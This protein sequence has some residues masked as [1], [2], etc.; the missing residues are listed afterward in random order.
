MPPT[1]RLPP[2]DGRFAHGFTLHDTN[3]LSGPSMAMIR[4]QNGLISVI[5]G[6]NSHGFPV[7]EYVHLGTAVRNPGLINTA[8]FEHWHRPPGTD[9][10]TITAWAPFVEAVNQVYLGF[11]AHEPPDGAATATAPSQNAAYA[12]WYA[13]QAVQWFHQTRTEDRDVSS[14]TNSDADADAETW[15][16]DE[17]VAD[18][19]EKL[20]TFIGT[21]KAHGLHH[22]DIHTRWL[23]QGTD[24]II[25]VL[26]EVFLPYTVSSTALA[27]D[28]Q[29]ISYHPRQ[30]WQAIEET[31]TAWQ[32]MV[33]RG[34]SPFP[35]ENVTPPTVF[36]FF[37]IQWARLTTSTL[38]LLC[39]AV[40]L[41]A[42]EPHLITSLPG[43]YYNLDPHTATQW[44][45]SPHYV[46][47]YPILILLQDEPECTLVES[48][49]NKHGLYTLAESMWRDYKDCHLYTDLAAWR[50]TTQDVTT[51]TRRDIIAM[52]VQLWTFLTRVERLWHAY[53]DKID[54]LECTHCQA[55]LSLI[56]VVPYLQPALDLRVFT[57]LGL[58]TLRSVARRY[59]PW[60]QWEVTDTYRQNPF[61]PDPDGP[62]RYREH[63]FRPTE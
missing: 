42:H 49:P 1:D 13:D 31:L 50:L 60:L 61:L 48:T 32:D 21:Y 12:D 5:M 58:R 47:K 56:P 40:L 29:Y 24:F 63:P 4:P 39:E 46:H 6:E 38:G 34:E 43:L 55:I 2:P 9:I 57:K 19:T 26:I 18:L 20:N 30:C 41:T 7:E 52:A 23:Q 10:R 54:E 16:F 28:D 17:H 35:F 36:D 45:A 51:Y 53:H 44:F 15:S 37:E 11:D 59:L 27:T 14:S 62:V 3:F 22:E 25:L 8:Q 33:A